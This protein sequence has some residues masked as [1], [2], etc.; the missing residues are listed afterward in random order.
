MNLAQ[1]ERRPQQPGAQ[2]PLSH[3]RNRGIHRAKQ[4]DARIGARKQRLNQLQIANSHRVEH[5]AT[6]PFIP[7][8]AVHVIEGPTLRRSHVIKNRPRSGGGG[9][10]PRQTKPFQRQHTKMIL[11]KRKSMIRRKDPVIQWSLGAGDSRCPRLRRRTVWGQP[12]PAVRPSK[13]RLVFAGSPRALEQRR[14]RPIQQF[15]RPQLLQLFLHP[16]QRALARKLRC[17]ELPRR[18]V[19]SRESHAISYLCQRR[20]KVILVR[21]QRR[22]RR[23]PGRHHARHFAPHQ[24]LRLR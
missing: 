1:I 11:E 2:Q 4:G 8:D 3:G 13:A 18:Q 6:L 24:F 9:R 17:P 12:P 15:L 22:I 21:P 10:P 5:Q 23:R 14:R 16:P 19:E 20:Q 7:P